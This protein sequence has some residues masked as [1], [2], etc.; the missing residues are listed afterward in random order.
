MSRYT[1]EQRE[2]YYR[3]KKAAPKGSA[4]RSKYKSKARAPVQRSR[5]LA[6]ALGGLGAMA[7]GA[8]FGPA[9]GIIGGALGN[10][11]GDAIKYFTGYGDYRIKDNALLNRQPGRPIVNSSVGGT[12]ISKT[13]YLGDLISSASANTFRVQTYKL[14]PA[15]GIT[16][17]W[18][19][20]I[21]ANYEEWVCEGIYFEFRSMSGDALTSTNTSLGTV[22]MSAQYNVNSEDFESKQEMQ[23]HEY[24]VSIKPSESCRYFVECAKNQTIL[25]NMYIRAPQNLVNPTI[26]DRRFSDLCDFQIASS[27]CQGTNVNLG[28]IHVTYQIALFKSRMFDTLGEGNLVYRANTTV[29]VTSLTP[30]GTPTDNKQNGIVFNNMGDITFSGNTLNFP[31]GFNAIKREFMIQTHWS[32]AGSAVFA[33]PFIASAAGGAITSIGYLNS[34]PNGVT[35]SSGQNATYL[36]TDGSSNSL[37]ITISAGGTIPASS[38]V[39]VLIYQLPQ[40]FV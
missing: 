7:G 14:N 24:G 8:A 34:P 35:T 30:W 27:G 9:G 28:E 18:L 15:D 37:A 23:N 39:N 16:F 1:P 5:Y 4:A 6:P 12:V 32:S 3:K 33:A 11:A 36:R 29:G 20:Q 10:M 40:S 2:K 17:P 13:E 22:S 38:V 26:Q 21:A 31:I 25:N 19:S